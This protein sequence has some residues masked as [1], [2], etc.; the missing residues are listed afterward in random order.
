[1]H[2][3]E[4]L[5]LTWNDLNFTTYELRINKALSRGKNNQLSV[6]TTKTGVAR[7]IKMDDKTLAVMNKGR[8]WL[9]YC[10]Y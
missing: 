7:T 4:S 5:A 2:K 1:M 10:S 9:F 8:R 6:K 3:G